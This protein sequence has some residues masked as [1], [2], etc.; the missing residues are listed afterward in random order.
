MISS[1]GNKTL[2]KTGY[3]IRVNYMAQLWIELI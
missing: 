2:N 1:R 3:N